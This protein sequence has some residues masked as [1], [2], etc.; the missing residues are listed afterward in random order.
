MKKYESKDIR[1]IA[2]VGHGKSGKTSLAEAFLYNGKATDR[3][4]RVD[5]GDSVMD[6]DPEEKARQ[7]TINS[8]FHHFSWKKCMINILDTPGD[9]N[10]IADTHNTLQVAD[11]AILV[12]E[13]ISG[14][15]V[16]TEKVW[17]YLNEF[18]TPR[19]IVVNKL[20]RENSDF[21]AIIE[22]IKNKLKINPLV[23]QI[24]IGKEADFT[25][26]VD[27]VKMK[28]FVFS[29]NETGDFKEGDIPDSC[30]EQATALR[31]KLIEDIAET[32]EELLE[33]F[34]DGQE[35]S[36]EEINSSIKKGI[37]NK[38]LIP[39]LCVSALTNIG[40]KT[41]MDALVEYLPSP[42]DREAIEVMDP[43]TKEKKK[44]EPKENAPLAAFV[45]KTI[46]DPYAG[47]LTIFRVFAGSL[48][49]DSTVYNATKK[50]KEKIGQILQLEGKG[51]KPMESAITGDI[52]ALAKLRETTTGDTFC[53]EK[54]ELCFEKIKFPSPVISYAL[55]PKSR[56]DED[57]MSN[58]LARLIEEDPSLT[59]QRE[60]QTHEFI[61]SGMGQI[62]LD[63][64]IEKLKRKFGVEVETNIPKI[65][66]KETIKG[67]TKIQ[68]KYKKQSG[69]RGQYGDAW[70]EIEPLHHG[71]GFEFADK[72]VGGAIPRNYIPSVEKGV[73]EAMHE[74][75]L[76]GYPVVDIKVSVVDGSYHE[77][78]SSDMAFK[79][80]ASM[81]FKKG[82][83]D[84]RPVLLEP[85][86]NVEVTVP[87]EMTGDIIGD[88]NSRRGRV[89]GMDQ[90]VGGQVVK[91][92]APLA[93]MLRY[94]SDLTSITS[95][96][97]MFTMEFDHYDEV[98][99]HLS[100]K[101]IAAAKTE[102]EEK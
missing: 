23:M 16:V 50:V 43:K 64:T 45:F 37:I 83:M 5:T 6:F 73:V 79:I 89:L 25:G 86:M 80:A 4:G 42:L 61:L 51:Q 19:L 12:I 62:H 2:L 70:L 33:K 91:A 7:L 75:V 72:I 13:A 102:K 63:A 49:A 30:K 28:G 40:I 15:Q 18:K 53:D 66:Y 21:Y 68:G 31:Q 48:N 95:G 59:I 74:G 10:F 82:F 93:E 100:E 84:C 94:A 34:L 54:N 87:D 17:Q 3:L 44:L 38:T 96:R 46:A 29:D 57:K 8:S 78:D 92:T 85:V 71:A 27:L 52:V 67:K 60:E 76:A 77:V 35:L 32:Q 20:D 22:N 14:V 101:I 11:G 98:P 47:K 99:A 65:P 41:A 56:G 26:I 36:A 39:M 81:G 24:P 90:G 88:L 58:A 97:G 1:N 55:A 9:A 69:G